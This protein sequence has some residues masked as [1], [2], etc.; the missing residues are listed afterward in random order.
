MSDFLRPTGI[1]WAPGGEHGQ[2]KFGNDDLTLAVFYTKS[3]LN[4]AKTLEHNRPFHENRAYVRI[5]PPGERLN[6]V[7]RPVQDSDKRRW[8][9]AWN[10]YLN[11][12]VQVPEGTPVDQL[13]VNHPAIADNLKGAGVFTI[14]QLANLSGNAI[15]N[16]GMGA[17]DWVNKAKTYLEQADKGKNFTAMQQRVEAA[18]AEARVLK[19]QLDVAIGQIKAL[20]Q[21]IMSPQQYT[22]QPGNQPGIDPTVERINANH[23]T[24]DLAKSKPDKPVDPYAI[25][26]DDF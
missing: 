10:D 1:Q 9:K 6:I 7:D 12:R 3:V 16:I 19:Q 23:T 20:E 26:T 4:E 18:E 25:Q 2:V 22:L 5:Q 13:F 15:D 21:R 17:Q 8:P 14:E 11:D 24:K